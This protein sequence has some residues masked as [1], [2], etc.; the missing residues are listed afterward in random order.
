MTTG[1]QITVKP[2]LTGRPVLLGLAGVFLL[3]GV[4]TFFFGGDD[5]LAA[6]GRVPPG[7]YALVLGCSLFNYFLRYRRWA[8]LLARR[9]SDVP[10]G[11]H[12]LIYIA[13]FA[14]TATPGKIGE[15]LRGIYLKDYG[16]PLSR[17]VAA[18]NTSSR[19]S[20]TPCGKAIA[21]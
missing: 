19:R 14:Y 15:A 7:V 11:A 10:F 5:V 4:S 6:L 18:A 2:R 1:N 17:T 21:K 9:G 16:V 3:Y 12:G 13:G 20:S 8:W